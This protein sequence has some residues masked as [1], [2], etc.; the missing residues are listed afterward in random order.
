MAPFSIGSIFIDD[1]N[2]FNFGM[3]VSISRMIYIFYACN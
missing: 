3:N 1:I 2:S